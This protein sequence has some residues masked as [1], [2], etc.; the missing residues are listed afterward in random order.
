ML[1]HEYLVVISGVAPR[2]W[3]LRRLGIWRFLV[4]TRVLGAGL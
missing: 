2:T 3:L 4:D 1:D